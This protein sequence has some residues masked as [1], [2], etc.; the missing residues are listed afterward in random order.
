MEPLNIADARSDTY[1]QTP[2]KP[3]IS[4]WAFLDF[5]QI[6]NVPGEPNLWFRWCGDTGPARFVSLRMELNSYCDAAPIME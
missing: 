6:A 5:C 1:L 3:V 2:K 4:V